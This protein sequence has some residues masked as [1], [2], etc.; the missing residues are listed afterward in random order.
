MRR[1]EFIAFL[2][3]VATGWPLAAHAQ[4][5]G[6]VYRI[7][8]IGPAQINAPSI[9]FYQAFLTQMGAHGFREGQN[10]RVEFRSLEDSRGMS[11]NAGELIRSQP[12]LIVVTGTEAALRSVAGTSQTIPI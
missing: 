3:G 7:G 6:K 11:V 10:L 4:E 5:P 2:G 8:F 1:R 9:A 12:E